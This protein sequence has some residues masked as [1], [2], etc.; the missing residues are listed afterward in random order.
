MVDVPSLGVLITGPG[1]ASVGSLLGS[2]VRFPVLAPDFIG[3]AVTRASDFAGR[4]SR[5]LGIGVVDIDVDAPRLVLIAASGVE[6]VS[7]LME[8]AREMVDAAIFVVDAASQPSRTSTAAM[9]RVLGD[10]LDMPLVVAIDGCHDVAEAR[11]AAVSMGAPSG[12]RMLRCKIGDPRSGWRVVIE[13]LEAAHAS[14]APPDG[15]GARHD[16]A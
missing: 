6:K 15:N 11:A 1:S 3:D 4:A 8:A 5:V 7:P 9:L 2:V 16:V 13:A 10:E 12:A 14:I